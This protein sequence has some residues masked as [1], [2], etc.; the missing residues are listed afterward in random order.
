MLRPL[1]VT[2]G[3]I[4]VPCR[5]GDAGCRIFCEAE[6]ALRESR[7][8]LAWDLLPVRTG[9]AGVRSSCGALKPPHRSELHHQRVGWCLRYS[10]APPWKHKA[11][12]LKLH[13]QTAH[14]G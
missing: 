5:A 7:G 9:Y 11:L 13:R 4:G 8:R 3:E 2:L 1:R 6:T 14:G 10:M 12:Y